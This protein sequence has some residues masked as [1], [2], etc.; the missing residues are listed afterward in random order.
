[1]RIP[2]IEYASHN[3]LAYNFS[4]SR[5]LENHYASILII[6]RRVS[7]IDISTRSIVDPCNICHYKRPHASITTCLFLLL[8]SGIFRI[9]ISPPASL[10]HAAVEKKKSSCLA[11]CGWWGAILIA[12]LS[13]LLPS[14]TRI[15]LISKQATS[16]IFFYIISSSH[17]A[18]FFV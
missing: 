15:F 9:K 8:P 6:S 1:M 2:Y 18:F 7:S 13:A 10:F 16:Y 3:T 14:Q 11:L 17:A 12:N 4:F 5:C